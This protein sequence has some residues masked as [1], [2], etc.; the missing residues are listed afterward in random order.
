VRG[1]LPLRVGEHDFDNP[2]VAPHY[3]PYTGGSRGAPRRVYRSASTD[4]STTWPRWRP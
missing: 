1:S 4:R 3:V 2:F